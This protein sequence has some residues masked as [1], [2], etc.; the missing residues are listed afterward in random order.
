M[1]TDLQF[2]FALI[3]ALLLV[4]ELTQGVAFSPSRRGDLFKRKADHPVSY[5]VN[6]VIQC[7]LLYAMLYG[8][9]PQPTD[10]S[11]QRLLA[12][13]EQALEL[14]RTGHVA[15]AMVIYD[16]LLEESDHDVELL[17]WRGVGHQHF[18]HA[19]LALRDFQRVIQLQP[20]NFDAVRNADRILSERGRWDDILPMWDQYIGKV[21]TNA[22][23]YFERAGT[24]HH[25]GNEPAA[26]ED[27]A[28]AC[29]LGKAEACQLAE[30]LK[31]QP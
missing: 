23:A 28:K 13:R 24:Q 31:A 30:R 27:I 22:E 3:L 6:I 20:Q 19:E 21:P 12:P 25:K 26:K 2:A 4:W 8:N 17:Y 29:E 18:N 9:H 16:R 11:A 15:D 1:K 7:A 14:Q 5:W 10:K